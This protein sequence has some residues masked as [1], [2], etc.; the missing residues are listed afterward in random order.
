MENSRTGPAG[1]S[2]RSLALLAVAVCLGLLHHADHVLRADHSGW[3]FR[4]AIT[5][6]TYSLSVYAVLFAAFLLRGRPALA[7]AAVAL[8][9]AVAQFSH[10]VFELP[11]DQYSTWA[12]GESHDPAHLGQPNLL[13]VES[14]LL[15]VLAAG[16]S[17]ALSV[18]LL[19]TVVSLVA[20]ARRGGRRAATAADHTVAR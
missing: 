7:A 15:G 1:A 10:V 17:V 4:E 2:R 3:P 11:A 16:L 12:S 20:D 6:F 9:L 8:T 14:P 18:A 13:G 5:P 19:A